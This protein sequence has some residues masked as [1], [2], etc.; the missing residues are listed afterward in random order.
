MVIRRQVHAILAE[1]TL[2]LPATYIVLLAHSY[3]RPADKKDCPGWKKNLP[4]LDQKKAYFL[5]VC[6]VGLLPKEVLRN[7]GYRQSKDA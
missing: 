6:G 1:T 2:Q 7:A 4:R 3:R 5:F